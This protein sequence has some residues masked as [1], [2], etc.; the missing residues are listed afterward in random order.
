MRTRVCA[1]FVV[2]T[3]TGYG[4]KHHGHV[5]FK[6]G[7][8]ACKRE[9]GRINKEA[10]LRRDDLHRAVLERDLWREMNKQKIRDFN[11]FKRAYP[12]KGGKLMVQRA[13]I[14]R[15]I[16]NAENMAAFLEALPA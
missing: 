15:G 12:T 16:L 4:V 13:P 11:S 6:G 7:K 8:K 10:A 14:R 9:C 3:P 1:A 2:K 5:S